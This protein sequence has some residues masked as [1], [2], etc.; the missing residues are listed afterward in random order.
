MTTQT[1][2]PEPTPTTEQIEALRSEAGA[3]GDREQVQVC[4]RAL[5]GDEVAIAECARVIRAAQ[6]Q[7]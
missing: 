5:A 4:D 6:A 2:I 1:T 7:R 3:A